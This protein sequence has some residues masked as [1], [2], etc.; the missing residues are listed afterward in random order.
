MANPNPD[1]S[2]LNPWKPG[3]SGNPGGKSSEHRKAEVRAAEL[4]AKVQLDLVE[5]LHNTLTAAQ[6]DVDKLAAIKADV[7][8]LLKDTQDRAYGTP[9]SSVDLE[10]PNGTMSGPSRIEI[11]SVAGRVADE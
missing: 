8:K 10:S 7:L 9:K 5:A 4:A 2:G 6:D 3:Q 11:V 1:T